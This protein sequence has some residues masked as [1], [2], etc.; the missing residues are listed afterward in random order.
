MT[1]EMLSDLWIDPF[2]EWPD[3]STAALEFEDDYHSFVFLHP[4]DRPPDESVMLTV[5][6]VGSTLPGPLARSAGA[7]FPC[8]SFSG[9]PEQVRIEDARKIRGLVL[10]LGVRRALPHDRDLVYR[11]GGAA[12]RVASY[13]RWVE[14]ERWA[15]RAD[16]LERHRFPRNVTRSQGRSYLQRP[17][18]GHLQ[19]L[20]LDVVRPE[21]LEQVQERHHRWTAT[22]GG[23]SHNRRRH[24]TADTVAE[25]ADEI[26]AQEMLLPASEKEAWDAANVERGRFVVPSPDEVELFRMLG[27]D[28]PLLWP[29]PAARRWILD[30]KS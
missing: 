16:E 13:P 23:H 5:R 9:D 17:W 15:Y 27:E 12:H 8:L 30:R 3:G 20:E 26:C 21:L 29:V 7:E 4:A 18:L 10:D 1:R 2:Y 24:T 19:A 6:P 25:L 14:D 22:W 28:L 11:A